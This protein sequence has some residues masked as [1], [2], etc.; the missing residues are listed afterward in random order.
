MARQPAFG[1][2][3]D[4]QHGRHQ[5]QKPAAAR[6][7]HGTAPIAQRPAAAEGLMQA[8]AKAEQGTKEGQGQQQLQGDKLPQAETHISPKER[9]TLP[10][11]GN[12]QSQ[13]PD[14][15]CPTTDPHDC[16]SRE[17]WQPH[18]QPAKQN[19]HQHNA[20]QRRPQPR[21]DGL[22]P[23]AGKVDRIVDGLDAKQ[24]KSQ[25]ADGL[26]PDGRDQAEGECPALEHRC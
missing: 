13:G 6:P 8:V 17:A 16:G 14:T 26:K 7:R 18:P 4:H 3:Q 21:A 12:G 5:G 2:K 9:F 11:G 24:H 25:H 15:P 10:R 22:H 1:R 20:A 19:G 23:T